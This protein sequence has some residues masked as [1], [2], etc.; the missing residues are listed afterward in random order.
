MLP[1]AENLI[2]SKGWD[3][4]VRQIMLAGK[5][6]RTLPLEHRNH[7]TEIKGCQSRV[8]LSLQATAEQQNAERCVMLAYSDSKIIRGVLALIQE[9]VNVLTCRELHDFDFPAYFTQIKLQA[10]LSE[11]RAN[12]IAEV[13]KRLQFTG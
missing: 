10:Y 7:T 5:A 9:K 2:Q 13:I 12:G 1:L 3:N 4:V 6:L 11:S 8:W